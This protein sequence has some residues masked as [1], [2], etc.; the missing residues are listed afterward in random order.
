MDGVGEI[1][2]EQSPMRRRSAPGRTALDALAGLLMVVV[3]GGFTVRA[4][5]F[6]VSRV[7]GAPPLRAALLM[8]LAL[9]CVAIVAL[10]WRYSSE[11]Y[12]GVRRTI[13]ETCWRS[14][15]LCLAIGLVA[16]L[17]ADVGL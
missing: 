3:G 17:V 14:G 13:E 9:A 7:D 1:G 8:M 5:W 11:R 10:S 4:I 15:A 12:A 2:V 16:I 6:C